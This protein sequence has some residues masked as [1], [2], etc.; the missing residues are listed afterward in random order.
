MREINIRMSTQNDDI[1]SDESSIEDLN[2]SLYEP[3]EEEEELYSSDSILESQPKNEKRRR[4]Q[5]DKHSQYK[6]KKTQNQSEATSVIRPNALIIST[7]TEPS[8]SNVNVNKANL[9]SGE[10][11]GKNNLYYLKKKFCLIKFFLCTNCYFILETRIDQIKTKLEEGIYI[12]EKKTGRK[13]RSDVW[14]KFAEIFERDATN[15]K[16]KVK[17]FF[18]LYCVFQN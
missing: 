11:L 12:Y 10:E 16:C 5:K 3:N 17:H 15:T 14:L 9:L 8:E 4:N 18:L 1:P 13:V 7:S 2:I 6:R